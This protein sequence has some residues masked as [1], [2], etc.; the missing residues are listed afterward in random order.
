LRQLH[1]D[2]AEMIYETKNVKIHVDI[3]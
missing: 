2:M 1:S 3:K